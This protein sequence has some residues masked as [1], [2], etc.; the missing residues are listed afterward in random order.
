[1]SFNGG[2]D[3]R[4]FLAS[5]STAAQPNLADDIRQIFAAFATRWLLI[6]VTIAAFLLVGVFTMWTAEP[7]YKSTVE[8]L[9]DPRVLQVVEKEVVPT[10][11]GSSS[12]GADIALVVSQLEILKSRSVL[13]E[14]IAKEGLE[15]NTEFSQGR[16]SGGFSGLLK[17]L[18]Y[19]PNLTSYTGISNF[20]QVLEN[21][22][23]AMEVDRVGNSYII[24]ITF[25]TSDPTLAAQ[26]ANSVAEIYID[27]W[28]TSTATSTQDV[29]IILEGRLDVLRDQV[30]KSQQA[31]EDYRRENGLISSEGVVVSEQ[32]IK[33]LNAQVT[34]AGVAAEAAKAY[35]EE[36]ERAFKAGTN[37]SSA[38]SLTSLA[39]VELRRQ[40]TEARAAETRA[41]SVYGDLHPTM[42]AAVDTRR[43][44][45]T[46][47]KQELSRTLERAQLAYKSAKQQE[48]ALF[49]RLQQQ[50]SRQGDVN[51]ASVKLSELSQNAKADQQLYQLFL[52]RAKEAREQ[53]ML[54]T[55]TVRII[56]VAK[57]STKPSEPK[58]S[59]V[60]LTSL[61]LGVLTGAAVA[62]ISHVLNGSKN[63][64]FSI[65]EM[66]RFFQKPP[67]FSQSVPAN[68]VSSPT[69]HP[70][71]YVRKNEQAAYVQSQMHNAQ[72]QETP[73]STAPLKNRYKPTSS[74][75]R[76]S[77]MQRT[78]SPVRRHT[79]QP[80]ATRR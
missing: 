48:G 55:N 28:V 43:V 67:Q 50:Q 14:L 73:T 51:N 74:G 78:Q 62:W 13:S 52:A 44:L 53:V 42:V 5:R 46:A 47:L 10:G 19:G 17:T 60:L 70:R 27:Q 56:S 29:A 4:R 75:H 68:A 8:I 11:L 21:V 6:F 71:Q 12:N 72:E 69:T 54:P 64:S 36:V 38:S 2:N 65:N 26:L 41:R 24:A 37:Q 58:L 45:E 25:G 34:A 57:P 30:Q 7:V 76:A 49:A 40:L 33:D 31:V 22:Q 15:Q 35:L 59:I 3:E 9:I 61:F 66:K 39:L 18:F 77:H 16:G 1:M 23:E 80:R 32:Q 20:D 63:V 79:Y